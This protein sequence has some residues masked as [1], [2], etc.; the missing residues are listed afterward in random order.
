VAKQGNIIEKAE[1]ELEVIK[2]HIK[3]VLGNDKVILEPTPTYNTANLDEIVKYLYYQYDQEQGIDRYV[4]QKSQSLIRKKTDHRIV[5]QDDKIDSIAWTGQ[6]I[7]YARVSLLYLEY[8]KI[9]QGTKSKILSLVHEVIKDNKNYP[10]KNQKDLSKKIG[11]ILN[12]IQEVA[13][14]KDIKKINKSI[15]K[16]LDIASLGD[17]HYHCTTITPIDNKDNI[18]IQTDIKLDGLTEEL[19]EQISNIASDKRKPLPAWF[20]NLESYDQFL[21]KQAAKQVV[22]SKFTKVIPT[23]FL[24][25]KLMPGLR[26]AYMEVCFAKEKDKEPIEILRSFRS[27]VPVIKDQAKN[28]YTVDILESLGGGFSLNPLI[29]SNSYFPSE[30]SLFSSLKKGADNKKIEVNTTPVNLARAIQ[31]RDL[32]NYQEIVDKVGKAIKEYKGSLDKKSIKNL[33]DCEKSL[34]TFSLLASKFLNDS[35][36]YKISSKMAQLVH[37]LKR[38][39]L[40]DLKLGDEIPEILTFCKSGK[41]RTGIVRFMGNKDAFNRY[42]DTETTDIII[43]SGHQQY[44]T[45]TNGGSA[46]CF[47][48]KGEVNPSMPKAYRKKGLA[49][50]TAYGNDPKYKAST[51][52]DE[53][54]DKSIKPKSSPREIEVKVANFRSEPSKTRDTPRSDNKAKDFYKTTNQVLKPIIFDNNKVNYP[55]AL[56]ERLQE[57]HLYTTE[58]N[59]KKLS[60]KKEI[61][62]DPKYFQKELGKSLDNHHQENNYRSIKPEVSSK[63]K[64][65]DDYGLKNQA[66]LEECKIKTF[67]LTDKVKLNMAIDQ[68]GRVYLSKDSLEQIKRNKLTLS[69]KIPSKNGPAEYLEFINGKLHIIDLPDVKETRLANKKG[70]NDLIGY[71]ENEK[72]HPHNHDSLRM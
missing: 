29:T 42:F 12:I 11:E 19:K 32:S 53:E 31:S 65:F 69:I 66:E 51:T 72:P 41:D 28:D 48:I 7:N 38:G 57:Y 13:Q 18:A 54:S 14:E 9:D 52:S 67:A 63:E 30:Y 61:T 22:D 10:I 50:D 2:N 56:I 21:A 59:P 55:I 26:N 17:E 36:N 68:G 25:S 64:T 16:A 6:F 20:L 27:G 60:I 37:D 35:D 15:K 34:T 1:K 46:F 47:G 45:G 44:L 71:K 62:N 5:K 4:D 8:N 24:A 23:Q 58:N 70:L 49:R 33:E 43:N 39:A 3:E 40:K